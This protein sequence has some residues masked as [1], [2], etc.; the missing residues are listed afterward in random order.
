MNLRESDRKTSNIVL[1][2]TTLGRDERAILCDVSPTGC[3]IELFDGAM[4]QR[5]ATIIFEVKDPLYFAGE[6]VWVR[7]SEAGVRFTRDLTPEVRSALE[8]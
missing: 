6:I 8:L 5:G 1:P 7:G 2:C 4:P 3:R